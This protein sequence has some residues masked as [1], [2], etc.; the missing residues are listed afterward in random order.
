[1]KRLDPLAVPL[2]GTTLIEAS[3][4]T[5]KTHTITTLYVR[6]LLE[7]KLSVGEILVVTYTNAATAELR[8]RVRA[9][10][11]AAH[12]ALCSGGA[13]G[14]EDMDRLARQRLAAGDVEDDRRRL[15]A[16]LHGFDEAA[17]FTIHGFCQRVLQEDAFES[18]VAFDTELVTDETVLR[19]Q[20][21]RDFWVREVHDAPEVLVRYLMNGPKPLDVKML[22]ALLRQALLHRDMPLL[23]DAARLELEAAR[24]GLLAALRS[25]RRSCGR[26]KATEIVGLAVRRGPCEAT[27]TSPDSDQKRVGPRCWTSSSRPGSRRREGVQA[28]PLHEDGAASREHEEGEADAPSTIFFAPVTSWSPP[29]IESVVCWRKP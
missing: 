1:M 12:A 9:R 10:L 26:R 20:V 28:P 8:G 25:W 23:P 22:D 17:I 27:S 24:Q 3:A 5:G 6:L 29:T 14:D 21:V 13:G 4:G 15:L 2:R 16:A 18:G 7:E 11:V 19:Q